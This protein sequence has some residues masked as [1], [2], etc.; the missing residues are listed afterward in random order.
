VAVVTNA[1]DANLRAA[2]ADLRRAR[3]CL[4]RAG[5]VTSP[6]WWTAFE[7]VRVADRA[8]TVAFITW[9]ERALPKRATP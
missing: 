2:T 7:A 5:L 9:L 6:E 1:E 4:S 3:A 8:F